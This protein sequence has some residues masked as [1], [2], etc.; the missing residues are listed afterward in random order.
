MR[1]VLSAPRGRYARA[2]SQREVGAAT[3]A[4]R[5]AT[6][7]D[8]E[9]AAQE[10]KHCVEPSAMAARANALLV[11]LETP[12]G[13]EKAPAVLAHAALREVVAGARR[14]AGAELLARAV[15][16]RKDASFAAP[17]AKALRPSV[18]EVATKAMALRPDAIA[19]AAGAA[20]ATDR[21]TAK[22]AEASLRGRC[23]GSRVASGNGRLAKA[24]GVRQDVRFATPVAKALAL[25]VLDDAQ[26]ALVERLVTERERDAGATSGKQGGGAQADAMA[27]RSYT[28]A[29]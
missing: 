24:A 27:L 26:D 8:V 13:G 1:P 16:A 12:C 21:A 15:N 23:A 4:L 2:A 19:R 10:G 9:V 11:P 18:P 14:V 28:I 17:I 22:P 3:N 29:R 6:S 5:L 7:R 25:T 20:I